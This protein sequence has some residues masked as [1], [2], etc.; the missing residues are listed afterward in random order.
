MVIKGYVRF[1]ICLGPG[2]EQGPSRQKGGD[3]FANFLKAVR[4]RKTSDQNGPVET[5]HLSSALA[6]LGN[7]SHRLER[8]LVY[9]PVK[10]R[11]V[12]DEQA[13]AM[14]R[15][16]YRSAVIVSRKE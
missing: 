16:K 9:D 12:G 5:A 2:R 6:H 13:N 3:H 15:R 7:I 10:E 14:L 1:E 4:S 11:F 8:Q